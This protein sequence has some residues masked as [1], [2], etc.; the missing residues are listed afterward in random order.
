[1]SLDDLKY[2]VVRNVL[3]KE[4]IELMKIQTKMLENVLNSYA[5]P[6]NK[7]YYFSDSQIKECFSFYSPLFTESLLVFLQPIIEKITK[8]D[9]LPTYSY[10]RTYYKNAL[11][12]RHKD[13]ES[14]E[15]SV[16]ICIK[17][18]TIPWKIWF[19]KDNEEISIS[20]EEGDLIIYK[21]TVLEHWRE[22][23]EGNEHI[24]FFLHYVD[25]NGIN[26]CFKYDNREMLGKQK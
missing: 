22:K 15:Y 23:Y 1:M 17:N 7:E 20:L 4:T 11:L 13:R 9:L 12:E 3:S 5:N 19:L 14:C 18:D 26:S 21:G 24:Q 25:K 2:I 8:K 16:T 10:M 6:T